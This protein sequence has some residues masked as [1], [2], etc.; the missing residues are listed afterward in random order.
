MLYIMNNQMHGFNGS[1]LLLIFSTILF[2]FLASVTV[3]ATNRNPVADFDGDGKTDISVFRPSNG[4]WYI[5][6]SSGGYLFVKWGL[7]DDTPMP[8]DYD[9]DGK[10]DIAVWRLGVIDR[11]GSNH[12]YILKSSDFTFSSIAFGPIEGQ[13]FSNPIAPADYDGDGKTDVANITQEYTISGTIATITRTYFDV[14][15]VLGNFGVRKVLPNTLS[16]IVVSADYDGDGKADFATY[17]DGLWTIEQ[18]TNGAARTVS[19]GLSDDKL[20]PAD[21]DGDGKAD[22]AVWRPSNGYWYWLSS[23]DGSFNSYQ[24]GQSDDRVVPGDYDGDGRID[25]AVV[26]IENGL[27]I[28]YI[29]QSTKGF[30]AEQFGMSG[31]V[32]IPR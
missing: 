16:G 14:S 11:S 9:G 19:F 18:S 4:Y 6:K 5:S 32:P 24:F 13:Y 3:S 15:S 27:E 7:S 1:R 23:R 20:V 25:F 12:W 26:R 17:K 8:G 28:W 31:D 22:I 10:T 2:G 30:R 29:Q 21:Y